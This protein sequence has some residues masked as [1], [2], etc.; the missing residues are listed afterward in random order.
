MMHALGQLCDQ[1]NDAI[2]PREIGPTA[3]VGLEHVESG[4]L[5]I[6]HTGISRGLASTKTKFKA[7]DVL[8][9]KLRPYLDKAAVAEIDG[10][11]STELLVLRPKTSVPAPLIAA[12]L[13]TPAFLDHAI[14]TTHGVNHPRTSWQAISAFEM[15]LPP[16]GE[17]HRISAA[18]S[19]ANRASDLEDRLTAA[20][21]ELKQAA[22]QQCFTRG[23]RGEEQKETEIGPVPASWD[24]VRLGTCCDVVSSS[25]SYTDFLAMQ[26]ISTAETVKAM[27]VKVSDMNRERNSV[28]FTHSAIEK[29]VP[30]SVAER[31]LVPPDTIVFP[32]RGAAIATNKKR[33]T[34]AWTVLDPNLIGVRAGERLTTA[35]LFYWFQNFDLRSIT[36]PGPTP[37]LNKKHLVPLS[38][39]VP[40]D[41][42]EQGEITAVFEAIDRS[43]DVHER[44]CTA[45]EQLFRTLLN[46]LLTGRLRIS[47][48]GADVV[49]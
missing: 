44:R 7:G 16:E 36:E 49:A 48:A 38:I 35:Y 47:D 10:V 34:T 40:S 28:R 39:P 14:R 37:Q 12:L 5:V 4:R 8:Y 19:T 43:L 30:R 17:W 23:L 33:L 46:D 45:L 31:R 9:G 22:M 2:D 24:V 42:G 29:H 15:D 13:H 32:K 26:D 11:C 21:R 1:A 41:H 25:L 3:Y 6:R 27:G 20:A 18:L